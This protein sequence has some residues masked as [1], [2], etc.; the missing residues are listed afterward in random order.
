MWFD[1]VIAPEDDFIQ[2]YDTIVPGLS[3]LAEN[4]ISLTMIQ[5][6]LRWFGDLPSLKLSPSVSIARMI[7]LDDKMLSNGN[8]G[9]MLSEFDPATT[10][11]VLIAVDTTSL[12]GSDRKFFLTAWRHCDHMHCRGLPQR[13][14]SRS[15]HE[16][17]GDMQS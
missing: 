14:V 6:T 5:D 10:S 8:E 12:E 3:C 16:D 11:L 7:K 15:Y 2:D 9:Q 4:G 17:F 1:R 13:N